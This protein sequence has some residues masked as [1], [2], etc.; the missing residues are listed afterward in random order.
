MNIKRLSDIEIHAIAKTITVTILGMHNQLGLGI[1][2]TEV[3]K[4]KNAIVKDIKNDSI[5]KSVEQYDDL[6]IN[7]NNNK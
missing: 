6:I 3:E 7:I 4:L 1:K 2:N 5:N